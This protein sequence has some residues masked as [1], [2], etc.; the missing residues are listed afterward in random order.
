MFCRGEGAI[1]S[2]P[3]GAWCAGTTMQEVACPCIRRG[4]TVRRRTVPTLQRR[5]YGFRQSIRRRGY[6]LVTRVQRTKRGNALG[7]GA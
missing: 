5:R 3:K 1:G 2:S 7:I 6:A 4:E